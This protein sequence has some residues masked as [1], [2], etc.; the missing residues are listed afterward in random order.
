MLKLSSFFILFALLSGC[1]IGG[2][3]QP[4]TE[5]FS[6]I[7][8]TYVGTAVSI[9][10]SYNGQVSGG[11]TRTAKLTKTGQLNTT[12]NA[13]KSITYQMHRQVLSLYSD[14]RDLGVGSYEILTTDDPLTWATVI[15]Y[16]S[17]GVERGRVKYV[18][19]QTSAG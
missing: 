4:E 6:N 13:G 17:A 8:G 11:S 15:M 9:S 2:S 14:R 19:S 18:I 5:D 1:W 3:D 10:G 12:D 16:D 7:A